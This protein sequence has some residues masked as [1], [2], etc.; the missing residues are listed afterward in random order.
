MTT[1]LKS[2]FCWGDSGCE[3]IRASLTWLKEQ[4]R[5]PGPDWKQIHTLVPTFFNAGQ[6]SY[7]L[8]V[9]VLKW[10]HV[11]VMIKI[12]VL[13]GTL[14]VWNK[15]PVGALIDLLLKQVGVSE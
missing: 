7:V 8:L 1:S 6:F 9:Y 5:T 2:D 4:K 15:V 11:M 3:L 13:L 14:N 12:S 10:Y